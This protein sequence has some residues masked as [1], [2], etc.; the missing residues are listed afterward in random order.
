MSSRVVWIRVLVQATLLTAPTPETPWCGSGVLPL[1]QIWTSTVM[2]P[3]EVAGNARTI[4]QD[5]LWLL[6]W[7]SCQH[8]GS[9]ISMRTFT[10]SLYWERT[11][12]TRRASA[13]RAWALSPLF[14]VLRWYLF[15]PPLLSLLLW[16]YF[17]PLNTNNWRH[18]STVSGEIP[19]APSQ[20]VRAVSLSRLLVSE[21]PCPAITVTRRPTCCILHSLDQ[22]PRLAQRRTGNS[23]PSNIYSN[24][25]HS[26]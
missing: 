18:S 26:L 22:R 3:T 1:S 7:M 13:S 16:L 5:S 17:F 6:S 24:C 10:V 21:A 25:L 15:A 14:V 19:T 11:T 9:L 8:S 4:P 2:V 20:L 23:T 12:S